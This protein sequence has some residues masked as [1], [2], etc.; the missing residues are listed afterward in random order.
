MI[1]NVNLSIS[2]SLAVV[3]RVNSVHIK[4][5]P[6]LFKNRNRE[7]RDCFILQTA[8]QTLRE[9]NLPHICLTF[10]EGRSIERSMCEHRRLT[11]SPQERWEN[12]YR[13]QDVS[14]PRLCPSA[15]LRIGN[16]GMHQRS[17]RSIATVFTECISV[18][19]SVV[20]VNATA[21]HFRQKEQDALTCLMRLNYQQFNVNAVI[22]ELHLKHLLTPAYV[23]C[24][25]QRSTA[26]DFFSSQN[27]SI[28]KNTFSKGTV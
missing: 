7:H 9:R 1:I 28:S 22:T 15:A 13:T 26:L 2:I 17:S 19:I 6:S 10:L 16:V 23:K 12:I 21:A 25:S 14:Q 27:A 4:A 8:T 11:Q 18:F 5:K 24:D 3:F 20:D